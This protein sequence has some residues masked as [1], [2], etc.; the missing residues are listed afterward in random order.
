MSLGLKIEV[1]SLHI[2]MRQD[3]INKAYDDLMSL[4]KKLDCCI[5]TKLN[6][7]SITIFPQY[8]RNIVKRIAQVDGLPVPDWGE[9]KT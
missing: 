9:E 2:G 4:A 3:I 7:K 5:S 8:D 6:E 1:E